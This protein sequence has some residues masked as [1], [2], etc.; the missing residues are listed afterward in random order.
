MVAAG[1]DLCA[2]ELLVAGDV[3]AIGMFGDF[4]SHSAE[5]LD[6]EGDAVGL[7][8]AELVG[9]ADMDASSG[10]GCDGGQDREFIDELGGERAGDGGAA[11][12]L[13]G[14]GDLDGADEFRMLVF[15]VEDGDLQAPARIE[16]PRGWPWWG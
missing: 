16:H 11:K 15:Q 3:H 14:C 13:W 10:V 5:V 9:V 6:D 7:F 2:V 8:D 12:A 4:G 1:V